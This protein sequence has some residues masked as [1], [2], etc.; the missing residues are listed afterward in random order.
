LV[1][2][3]SETVRLNEL[4]AGVLAHDLRNPLSAIL[5]A[6][7]LAMMRDESDL[8][9]RPLR[10]ILSSGERMT[11]MIEQLLDFTRV[12]VGGGFELDAKAIDLS[13]VC[14]SILSELEIANPG[15][16]MQLERTENTAGSW[17]NDRLLQVFSNLAGNAVQH[18]DPSGGL[19]IDIDGTQPDL[20]VARVHN[21][22]A[23]PEDLLPILFD[24]FRG[25][26]HRR[27]ASQGLGLGL[28]IVKEIVAAHGGTIGV[29]SSAENGTT[30]TVA[31]PR[32]VRSTP[33][34]H[35]PSGSYL[36]V[37]APTGLVEH[38]DPVAQSV[39]F[40]VDGSERR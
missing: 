6:A 31:L 3:L 14:Q 40:A 39:K 33:E 7:Q 30:F 17:D 8:V 21:H 36:G 27:A 38:G 18:G 23:I 29:C 15:W 28:F 24:P 11:R 19:S 2:E 1:R 26:L 4:F 32:A 35:D 5:T 16:T 22:G 34:Q 37:R 9:T 25:T 12:R 13:D 20:V 10:R